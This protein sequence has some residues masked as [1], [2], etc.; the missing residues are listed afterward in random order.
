TQADFPAY[1]AAMVGSMGQFNRLTDAAK[2]NVLPERVKVMTVKRTASFENVLLDMK[3][4][5]E[6]HEEHSLL[7][8]LDLSTQVPFNTRIKIITK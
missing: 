5:Q 6:R 1:Q 2:I 4:P 3:V 8:N 7:N